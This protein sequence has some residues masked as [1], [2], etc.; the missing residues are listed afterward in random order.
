[1]AVHAPDGPSSPGTQPA[2]AQRPARWWNGGAAALAVAL[3]YVVLALHAAR[4]KGVAYDELAHVTAG[5]SYWLFDDYR[6]DPE[7]GNLPQRLA[8]LAFAWPRWLA[9][10]AA[11]PAFPA[12]EQVEWR[13]SDLWELGRQLLFASGNDR[14]AVLAA[15]RAGIAVLGAGLVLLVYLWSRALFGPAGAIVSALACA[16]SPGLLAHGALATSDL[17]VSAALTGSLL[18]V[19]RVLQRVTPVRVAAAG[20]GVGLALVCKPSA[21]LLAPLSLLLV[22]LRVARREPLEVSGDGRVR[23]VAGRA[24]R[25]A[26][27]AGAA[28][29]A[30]V[31]AVTVVWCAY[32]FRYATS[33]ASDPPEALYYGGWPYVEARV[34]GEGRGGAP[35]QATLWM[36]DRRLLP[37]SWLYGL[38]LVLV[39]SEQRACFLDGEVRFH[40]FADF[41]PR[42]FAY[43]STLGF[44]ALL[45]LALAAACARRGRGAV[46]AWDV[47]PPLLLVATVA[48][49]ALGTRL[50]IGYRHLLPV[51][52]PLCV[53]A[54]AAT[55]W[56]RRPPGASRMGRAARAAAAAVVLALAG[57]VAETLAARPHFL[58]FFNALAGGPAQGWRRL[59]DSSLDWGQDLPE[60]AA[61]LR[62]D[63]AA[64]QPRPAAHLSYFGTDRPEAHGIEARWL[65]GYPDVR[66]EAGLFPL[67]AGVYC[68][69]ATMLWGVYSPYPAPWSAD[70]EREWNQVCTDLRE[71]EAAGADPARFRE[72]IAARGE[73]W[74]TK[75]LLVAGWLRLARL[76]AWLRAREASRQ[77]G[78]AIL[79]WEL[80]DDEVEQALFGPPAELRP[81]QPRPPDDTSRR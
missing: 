12:R 34:A 61:W 59:V 69:S 80:T 29:A 27:L 5:A 19:L 16:F 75:R 53:L 48:A 10:S 25:S 20:L 63:V 28:L 36:R 64:R 67:T 31:L 47:L 39:H 46:V 62:T 77:F 2:G 50:N 37:E 7:N 71:F 57:L 38:A 14:R 15:A 11:P 55:L 45:G 9:D 51:E 79:V 6:L 4:D 13:R 42:A 17:A 22:V 44:L 54:G 18:L 58:G 49:A 40:G 60:L 56:W 35:A 23:L 65:P 41:Y 72:F 43:K 30:L 52:P 74:W 70:D 32:G 66:A 73:A 68:V 26:W 76:C 78:H 1:M 3:A 81:E 21:L 8:T 24:A 33:P